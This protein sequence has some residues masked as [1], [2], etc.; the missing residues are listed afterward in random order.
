M[1]SVK[2]SLVSLH[3]TVA[4]LGGTALFSH[5][6]T[7]PALDITLG[8]SI[9]ACTI[10]FVLVFSQK[11]QLAL[12]TTRDYLIALGL[13]S[14][15]AAHWVTYFASMQYA[16]VSV[17]VIALFTF[18][19][20]TVLLEPLFEKTKLNWRDFVSAMVVLLGIGLIVPTPD[21]SNTT[22]LG[23]IVGVASALL[24]SIRNLLHRKHFSHYDGAK[25]MAWQTLVICAVLLPF[26][27]SGLSQ[28]STSNWLWLVLLGT[29]FTAL[30][31]ALIAQSL[32]HLQA[33]T[34]SLVASMQ[35]I[36]GVAF[37][38]IILSESPSWQTLLGGLLVTSASVYETV[39]THKANR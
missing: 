36:Y 10:L 25:A 28:A 20:I 8:R 7:L 30:P 33:K 14:I 1:H 3:L 17:G 11:R 4:L 12:E 22:T 27:F 13:G 23:V 6:I 37:S 18:P 21:L 26:G 35:P 32:K 16:G 38:I 39:V 34:F 9:F 19:V 5:I 15:M 31:H 29:V 24:Y 2:S